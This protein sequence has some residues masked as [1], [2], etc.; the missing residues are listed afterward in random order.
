MQ[1]RDGLANSVTVVLPHAL[2]GMG[3]VGKTQVAI[4]YA[5]RY[6]SDY[7]LVWW[8]PA[9]QPPLVRAS[10]AALAPQ[11]GLPPAT[12]S[13]IEGAANAVLD[14]L[15]RGQP[16]SRWLLIFDN[17][18]QP[19]D[20]TEVIPRGGPGHVL[21]TSR[22]HRWQSVVDTVQVDV[23]TRDE[24]IEFLT[25]R[26]RGTLDPDAADALAA[27]LGYLPL[28]LEQ[29]AALQSETGMSMEEYLR[30]LKEQ[31]VSILDEGKSADYPLSM[32]AA[33][34]LSVSTLAQY[35]PEAVELLR[36]CAFLGPEPIPR[37][38]F[39]RGAHALGPPLGDLLA[40]PIRLARAIRELGRFA[41]VRIEGRTMVIH[42]LIQA[43]LRDALQPEERGHYRDQAHLVLA[44]GA[45][46][47]PDDHRLWPAYG[48]L[49]AHAAAP[50]T[51]LEQ[52]G[53][54][55]VRRFAV[56][57]VRYLYNSGDLGA[58]RSFAERFIGAWT[59]ATPEGDLRLLRAKREL[60]NVLRSL[61]QYDDAYALDG[62]TLEVARRTFGERD[63][64]TLA[65]T[66][67]MGGDMRARGE[68][69]AALEL[70][71]RSLQT[72]EEVLGPE[73][74]LTLRMSHNL[75]LDYGLNS[76]YPESRDLHGRTYRLRNE[77]PTDIPAQEVVSSWSGLAR[78]LRLCGSYSEARDV[79]QDAYDYGVAVLG[80]EHPRT[81]EAAIDLSIALRR[82]A[83]SYADAEEL[84]RRVFD[85]ARRRFGQFAPLTLAA[86]VS[87]TNIQRTSS[88]IVEAL[89]LSEGASEQYGILYGQDHPYY[90]GCL[91]NVALMYRVNGDAQRARELNE[92][93]LTGL[94]GRLGRGH[95]Y[96]LTVAVNLASDL[97]AVGDVTEARMLGE[98]SLRRLR[99][100][101]G[102]EHPLTLGCAANL[103]ADLRAA[104]DAAEADRL[105]NVTISCY[106]ETLGDDHPDTVVA[107]EGRRLDFDFDS[108]Q[109]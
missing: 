101:L 9:D 6:G 10:L 44:A 81:L 57:M 3:G 64:F 63:E 16:F 45:P 78:A 35:Q 67:S 54:E 7:D 32:T 27:E 69:A 94:D 1:L 56:G 28:A 97:A 82:I 8:I 68:F 31:T 25:R 75:A 52:S 15:R 49:V 13:G 92:L 89:R 107:A 73:H 58:A 14:A 40:D 21:V 86:I 93:A 80:P 53:N 30:L 19:E 17:A 65:V 55:A 76:R 33:W 102:E 59:P 61:G 38:L 22:N 39:P 83:V 24:S 41:L 36:C 108:P 42:R 46:Q 4:E 71:S 48:E 96:S 77:R 109:I 87:L 100:L 66:L 60:A 98:D 34:K 23:F 50:A 88:E 104:G 103:V 99:P 29:A 84:A 2:Q 47:D 70:D 72:H 20:L 26:I 51:Q 62:T 18:D 85:Q 79:G 5:Y 90:Y 12:A 91:G 105:F 11:L 37:D 95:H 43:L 106:R 74:P